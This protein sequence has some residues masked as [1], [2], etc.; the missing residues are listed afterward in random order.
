MLRSDARQGF[1]HSFSSINTVNVDVIAQI[2]K[3]L[4]SYDLISMVFL[5][6][7]VADTALQRLVI[8]Q[9]VSRDIGG[10]NMNLLSD[11]AQNA[12]TRTSWKYEFLEA[13]SI[14]QLNRVIRRLGFNVDSVKKHYLPD[15]LHVSV[16]INLMKKALYKLCENMTNQ[17]FV[18]LQNTLKTYDVDTTE[19]K[20]CELVFLELMSKKF[21]TVINNH[22]GKNVMK[23]DKL[24]QIIGNI[25]NLKKFASDLRDIQRLLNNEVEENVPLKSSTPAE[26][27]KPD[28]EDEI[29]FLGNDS[30]NLCKYLNQLDLDKVTAKTLKS[31]TPQ[32]NYSEIYPIK[33]TKRLGVCYIINQEDFYPS[34]ESIE[35]NGQSEPLEKRLGSSSDKVNL[36]ETMKALNFEVISH[37]NLDHKKM[38]E[39]IMNI[40]EYRV[41]HDDSMFILCILSHGVRGH[42]YAADTIKVKVEDIQ[43]SIDGT[44]QRRQ[45]E[46][47]KVMLIQ[48]CQ[49]N[50]D[51]E[52]QNNKKALAADN[53]NNFY[54]RKSHFLIY[55]AAAPELEAYRDEKYGS[56]FIQMLC[57]ILQKRVKHEHLY[58]IFTKV[59]DGVANFCTKVQKDQVPIFE[60][61]LRKKLYMQIPTES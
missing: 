6:Y 23:I 26:I 32:I 44:F 27:T 10:R 47:P 14:C 49:V 25:F 18:I 39:T 33:N 24:A 55:W 8:Y 1:D 37:R 52:S 38:M 48:A 43:N 35:K 12:Q 30:D 5:L 61:T 54:L 57:Y 17:D 16:Y 20:T 53:S 58:D 7:D 3:E 2:E 13:L 22:D 42:V 31:D 59:T 34:K 19:Y 11:W 9:R 41:Q 36:E 21:I 50:I 28:S 4:E 51:T 46:I 29:E 60:S 56:V 40:V 45:L 15:N